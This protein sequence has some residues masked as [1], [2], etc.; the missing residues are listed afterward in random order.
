MD[1]FSWIKFNI[2]ILIGFFSLQTL[3]ASFNLDAIVGKSYFLSHEEGSDVYRPE[4]YNFPVSWPRPGFRFEAD[5][6]FTF[7]SPAPNDGGVIAEVGAWER[8]G[9]NTYK[10]LKHGAL[11]EKVRLSGDSQRVIKTRACNCGGSSAMCE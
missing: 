5:G 9:N 6:T 10:L 11:V 4:G 2:V 8:V 7:F 3:A 1:R